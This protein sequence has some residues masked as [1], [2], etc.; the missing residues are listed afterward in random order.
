MTLPP[1]Q[2]ESSWKT[3]LESEWK[4]PYLAKLAQFVAG[5]RKKGPVYPPKESVFAAFDQVPYDKVK[6]VI[7]G[8]D[9]YH[10]AGQAHGLSFSVPKG[11]RP[12][13]S[14]KNIFK[15]IES[16]LGISP[17]DHGCLTKWSDQGILLLNASLTVAAG[18][19]Q[20]HAK[21]GWETFTDAVIEALVARKDPVIFVMWGKSAQE[22]C[23]KIIGQSTNRHFM[24]IASHPSPYSAHTSFFGCHHFSKINDLLKQMKKEPIDWSLD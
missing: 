11:V 15:E 16:D 22:K 3:A 4:K 12:P 6:V 18:Q 23:S 7:M 1:P 5:E 21:Q 14:L 10:G 20:S 17:P 2:L 8:Q 13:P 9:P 19:P 24:L